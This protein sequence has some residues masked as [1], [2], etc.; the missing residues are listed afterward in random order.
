MYQSQN[1]LRCLSQRDKKKRMVECRLYRKHPIPALFGELV[2]VLQPYPVVP[3][4]V[5]LS[6]AVLVLQPAPV[7]AHVTLT[8]VHDVRPPS[9]A[10]H[11]AVHLQGEPAEKEKKIMQYYGQSRNWRG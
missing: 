6:E 11:V 7:E 8:T 4:K 1:L 10:G 5:G 3:V 2:H 9:L